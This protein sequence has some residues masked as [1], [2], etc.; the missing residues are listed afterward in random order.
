MLTSV[1]ILVGESVAQ[2]IKCGSVKT[3]C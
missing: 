1:T 3:L 2:A